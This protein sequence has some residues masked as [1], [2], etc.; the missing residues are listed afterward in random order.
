MRPDSRFRVWRTRGGTRSEATTVEVTT[1]S[2]AERTAPSRSA[3]DHA[4]AGNRS[5]AA[6]AMSAK[7]IGIATTECPRPGMPL[8]ADELSVRHEAVGEER[9][10]ERELD[11]VDEVL[12]VRRNVGGARQCEC[13][14]GSDREDGNR[15]D[16]PLKET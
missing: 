3:S 16:R 7:V 10:N 1:G 13:D 12:A 2:V 11:H 14:T 5:C 9:E 4:R 15:E 6:R 8:A